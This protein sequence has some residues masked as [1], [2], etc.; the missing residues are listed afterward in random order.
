MGLN[1]C[2]LKTKSICQQMDRWGR[3]SG[4]RQELL[5][6]HAYLKDINP[7][8]KLSLEFSWTKNYFLDLVYVTLKRFLKVMLRTRFKG[9][10]KEDVKTRPQKP[11][12][13]KK[14]TREQLFIQKHKRQQES[15]QVYF[16]TRRSRAANKVKQIIKRDWDLNKSDP[17]LKYPPSALKELLPE[18]LYPS[19]TEGNLARRQRR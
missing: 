11:L 12:R 14:L 15:D 8:L 5:Q 18:E 2:L 3:W 1:I 17:Y 10:R 13:V 9:T 6:F 4:S 19:N 7:N 16:V